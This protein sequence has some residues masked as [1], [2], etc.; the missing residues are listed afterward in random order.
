MTTSQVTRGI[1][2]AVE[3]LRLAVHLLD[4]RDPAR[5]DAVSLRAMTAVVTDLLEDAIDAL[6]EDAD[7]VPGVAPRGWAG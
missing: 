3:L 7:E 6:V 2:E 5:M 4:D 1:T